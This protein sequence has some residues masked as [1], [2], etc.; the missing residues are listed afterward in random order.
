MK[1][2]IWLY[3]GIIGGL[4]SIA[5]ALYLYFWVRKQ[6]PGT[7]RAQEVAKWIRI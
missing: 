6:D 3:I 7:A 1:F 5:V 4:F 2:D